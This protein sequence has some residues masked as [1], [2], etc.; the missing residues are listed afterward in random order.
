MLDGLDDY[1]LYRQEPQL[2]TV[3]RK[4]KYHMDPDYPRC[5]RLVD[6]HTGGVTFVISARLKRLLDLDGNPYVEFLPV[7]IVDLERRVASPDYFI[8]NACK[9]VD[10]LDA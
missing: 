7:A 6:A 3:K 5:T 8:V 10:C 9:G 1:K 4:L 2:P